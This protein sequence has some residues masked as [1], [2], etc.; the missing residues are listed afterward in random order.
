MNKETKIITA[1]YK[2]V[3]DDEKAKFRDAFQDCAAEAWQ[4]LSE[5]GWMDEAHTADRAAHC[6]LAAIFSAAVNSVNWKQARKEAKDFTI[7]DELEAKAEILNHS[8]KL[9]I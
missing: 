3:N 7:L 9:E 1:Y 8:M 6:A 2:E 4:L 5:S